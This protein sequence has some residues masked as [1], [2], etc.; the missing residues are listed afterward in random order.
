[1]SDHIQLQTTWDIQ[2]MCTKMLSTFK[3]DCENKVACILA[4]TEAGHFRKAHNVQIDDVS[5]G[6]TTMGNACLAPERPNTTDATQSSFPA[7]Q[8]TEVKKKQVLIPWIVENKKKALSHAFGAFLQRSSN[9]LPGKADIT[10]EQSEF[11]VLQKRIGLNIKFQLKMLK[12]RNR[13]IT[14]LTEELLSNSEWGFLCCFKTSG[15]HIVAALSV[16]I[17]IIVSFCHTCLLGLLLCQG[18]ETFLGKC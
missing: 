14:V 17:S 15:E 7:F 3:Q 10:K 16:H 13:Y 4:A 8:Y 9:K 6:T 2:L 12:K 18:F 1:M 5:K 11:N